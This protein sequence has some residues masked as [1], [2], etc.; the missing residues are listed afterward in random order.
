MNLAAESGRRDDKSCRQSAAIVEDRRLSD[1][2]KARDQRQWPKRNKYGGPVV[3]S[4]DSSFFFCQNSVLTTT[5]RSGET[6]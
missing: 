2:S 5:S 6:L 3:L 1:G 4:S